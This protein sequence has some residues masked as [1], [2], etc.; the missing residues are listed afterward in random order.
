MEKK[1]EKEGLEK[2]IFIRVINI[3]QLTIFIV[4]GLLNWDN[5]HPLNGLIYIAIGIVLVVFIKGFADIIDLL[6]S[7]NNKLDKR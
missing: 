6:D 1:E 5:E 2:S 4:A 7:I 3:F